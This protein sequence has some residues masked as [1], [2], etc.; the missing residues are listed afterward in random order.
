MK[1]I[2]LSLVALLTLSTM[3]YAESYTI[4]FKDY[5]KTSDN[6]TAFTTSTDVATFVNEGVDFVS[7]ITSTNN[8]YLGKSG[9]GL[10]FSSGS[11]NGKLNLELTSTAKVFPTSIVV[12]ACAF[13]SSET[14]K[15]SVNSSTAQTLGNSLS[16][17]TFTFDGQKL[18]TD[19]SFVATKRLYITKVVVNY[20][21]QEITV[22][23]NPK[24]NIEA[25]TFYNPQSVELSCATEGATIYY[26]LDGSEPNANSSVYSGAI[27]VSETTTIKAIAIKDEVLSDVATATYTIIPN[28]EYS[29]QLA[30]S[31]ENGGHYIIVGAS[32]DNFYAMTI[33]QNPNNRGA[34][35]VVVNDGLIANTPANVC[36]FELQGSEG[37]WSFYDSVNEGY[38]YNSEQANRLKVT[39]NEELLEYTKATITFNNETSIASIKFNEVENYN[40]LFFN[41]NAQN[42][43]PLFSCYKEDTS[44]GTPVYLYQRVG[45][46]P[47]GIEDTMVDENVP[48]EY[49]NLQGVKVANPENGIFIKKQGAKATKVI[50]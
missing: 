28:S 3:A 45:D 33:T 16:E 5:G 35:T 6:S 44:A 23:E 21:P 12:T 36:E 31:V 39:N 49:Y 8:C 19:L 30:T 46:I 47:T 10:K 38:L 20:T 48:V 11:T 27:Q 1:K 24:F 15:L 37:S 42:N 50:L 41:L 43:N 17:Y 32:E 25:G 2:L 26:T 29:Y 18:L 14:A 4:T 34:I 13:K 22:V 9:Y 7:K 40:N